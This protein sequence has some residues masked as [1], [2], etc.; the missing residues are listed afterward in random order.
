MWLHRASCA[1]VSSPAAYSSNQFWFYVFQLRFFF[2]LFFILFC[3]CVCFCVSFLFPPVS[4]FYLKKTRHPILVQFEHG[5]PTNSGSLSFLI[6]LF[7]KRP[8][9]QFWFSERGLFLFLFIALLSSASDYLS[10]KVSIMDYNHLFKCILK[11]GMAFY[12]FFF[13]NL[14][15]NSPKALIRRIWAHLY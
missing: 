1:G 15:I 5:P 9:N 14:C 6:H 13:T 8:A 7:G 2:A 3:V 12:F 10:N 11:L 4:V